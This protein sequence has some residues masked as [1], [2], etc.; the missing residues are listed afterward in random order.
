[1]SR[2]IPELKEIKEFHFSVNINS[3]IKLIRGNNNY[4]KNNLTETNNIKF[5]KYTININARTYYNKINRV[6]IDDF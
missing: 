4:A 1:M 2:C 5:S 3:N 6:S